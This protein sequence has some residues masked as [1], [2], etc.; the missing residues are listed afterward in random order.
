AAG[1]VDGSGEG[2]A[3]ISC[4]DLAGIYD[5]RTS[6]GAELKTQI[7]GRILFDRQS[8][9]LVL[10]GRNRIELDLN[11]KVSG[12]N[13]LHHTHGLVGASKSR[14]MISPGRGSEHQIGSIQRIAPIAKR[15]DKRPYGCVEG[16]ARKI[17][18]Y[19]ATGTRASSL[20]G[21][22]RDLV[23]NRVVRRVGFA[24]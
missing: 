20:G 17:V 2:D 18:G 11:Q 24:A 22:K 21:S 7:I 5:Q 16:R 9:E 13:W 1:E 4:N 8:L 15:V 3:F 14:V 10:Q 6:C 23:G 19:R 12:T